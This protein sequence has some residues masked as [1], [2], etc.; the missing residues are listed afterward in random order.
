MNKNSDEYAKRVKSILK[1][2]KEFEKK[3]Y[4]EGSFTEGLERVAGIKHS[5]DLTLKKSY[6]IR[7]KIWQTLRG[8]ESFGSPAMAEGRME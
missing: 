6:M 1:A 8:W 7:W 4:A 2:L 3:E 5:K